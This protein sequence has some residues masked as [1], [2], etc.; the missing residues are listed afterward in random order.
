MFEKEFKL[1]FDEGDSQLDFEQQQHKDWFDLMGI[2]SLSNS[3]F[4]KAKF[5]FNIDHWF[6]KCSENIKFCENDERIFGNEE[7]TEDYLKYQIYNQQ[8]FWRN[9][10]YWKGGISRDKFEVIDKDWVKQSENA[11]IISIISLNK[12]EVAPVFN[13]SG[14]IRKK[15][16]RKPDI[17]G[18]HQRK[19]IVLKSLLRKIHSFYWRD[20]NN[21]TKYLKNKQKRGVLFYEACL[22]QYIQ[23]K[24][25]KEPTDDF[26][27]TLG[28]FACWKEMKRLILNKSSKDI[29]KIE[30]KEYIY[31]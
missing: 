22:K 15:I 13:K 20:I 28:G 10:N 19:D 18:L 17:S 1:Y 2:K 12:S 11:S 26:V 31:W 6:Q 16:G 4:D 14:S 27:L 5:E 8:E 25:N 29:T 30:K 7:N 24:F 21:E 23:S 9:I 3:D